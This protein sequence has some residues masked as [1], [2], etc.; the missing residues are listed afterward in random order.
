[1]S[2]HYHEIYVMKD[3]VFLKY[4]ASLSIYF[5]VFSVFFSFGTNCAYSS[6][7]HHTA[8]RQPGAPDM[9]LLRPD[10]V[11]LAVLELSSFDL[12]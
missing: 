7:I 3:F 12:Y 1:M 9:Y 4:L 5:V 6:Y 8:H 2:E 10:N 11:C